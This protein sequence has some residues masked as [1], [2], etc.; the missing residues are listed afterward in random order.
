M[1][2][3]EGSGYLEAKELTNVLLNLGEK[4]TQEEVDDLLKEANMDAD[5]QL[6]YTSMYRILVTCYWVYMYIYI[7]F[8][9]FM[10]FAGL[11]W[12]TKSNALF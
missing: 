2:D 8:I 7:L 4:L 1:F 12:A 3:K 10:G 9:I 5:G 11:S 6:N